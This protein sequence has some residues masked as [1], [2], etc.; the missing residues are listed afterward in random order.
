MLL[1]AK[2]SEIIPDTGLPR[3]NAQP[4]SATIGALTTIWETV[5]QNSPIEPDDDFFD[6]GGNSLSAVTLFVEI[7]KFCGRH[8]PPV[9]IYNAPTIASLATELERPNTSRL[10]PLVLLRSGSAAA[11]VFIAHGLGGS[12]I[13]FYS[14]V[15]LIESD[16]PIYGM[17]ARG[18][19]GVD[20]PFESIEEMAQYHLEAI[21]KI[22]PQGPYALVGYS[23]G[24]LVSMEIAHRLVAAGD[25]VA[26]LAMLD[27]Y[28]FRKYLSFSQRFQLSTRLTLKRVSAAIG[29]SA[30][31]SDVYPASP[32]TF[33]A[34]MSAGRRASKLSQS[35]AVASMTPAMLRAAE[36]AKDALRQYRPRFYPGTIKFV[37]AETVTDFP[38]DPAA[39]WA[40]LTK[41]FEV[42]TVPGDHLGMIA[43][44]PEALAAVISRYL[45][46]PA[47][48]PNRS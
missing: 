46:E 7:E 42:E 33:R 48:G 14:L 38:A 23:L 11:P 47:L 40:D 45:N 41:Q 4:T 3:M 36:I 21:K 18:I 8:L 15:T 28:P 13:D 30:P 10:P 22:Q 35:P 39:I 32:A 12:V 16:R 31:A 34:Q 20:D 25:Q 37:R 26:L 5:L 19:D 9:M 2:E 24:G 6:L 17:Q 43:T 29:I 44:Y 27:A 1:P